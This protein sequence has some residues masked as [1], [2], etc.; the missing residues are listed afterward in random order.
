MVNF[1]LWSVSS[2]FAL[3]CIFAAGCQLGIPEHRSPCLLMVAGGLALIGAVYF[4]M[5][6]Q[7]WSWLLAAAGCVAI[8]IAALWNGKVDGIVHPMHHVI[9]IALCIL[10]IIG[11]YYY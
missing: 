4:C 5:R 6:G 10:L 8:C 7:P 9:R 2:L 11:F 1:V 3:L